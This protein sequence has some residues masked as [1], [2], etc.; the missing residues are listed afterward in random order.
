MKRQCRCLTL[1]SQRCRRSATCGH[2]CQ[3]HVLIGG[4]NPDQLWTEFMQNE[5]FNTRLWIDQSLGDLSPENPADIETIKQGFVKSDPTTKKKYLRW[6]L[7]SYQDGGNHMYQDVVGQMSDALIHFQKIAKLIKEPQLSPRDKDLSTYCGLFG[8]IRKE[9]AMRGLY[10]L[11][12]QY[13]ALSSSVKKS[14]QTSKDEAKK[15]FEDGVATI[16]HPTTK[17][18]AVAYGRGTRWCTS[19]T[20]QNM[21]KEY[22]KQGPLYIIIPKKPHNRAGHPVGSPQWRPD[23]YQ[24]HLPTGSL[25]NEL[26]EPMSLTDYHV[27]HNTL[28]EFLKQ[29]KF[30]PNSKDL[31]GRRPLQVTNNEVMVMLL[32]ELGAEPNVPNGP[33]RWVRAPETIEFLLQHHAD[34][35]V[36]DKLGQTLLFSV[37]DVQTAQLLLKYGADPFIKDNK[38]RTLLHAI[39]ESAVIELLLR[40]GLDPN[41]EDSDGQTPLYMAKT[42]EKMDLLLKSGAKANMHN[43]RGET[44]LHIS[45]NAEIVALLLA[46]NADPNGVNEFGQTPLHIQRDPIVIELLLA[47][48]ANPDAKNQYGSTPLHINCGLLE[49][50]TILLRHKANPNI[51]NMYGE[52]PL[53]SLVSAGKEVPNDWKIV[54]LLLQAGANI[55]AKDLKGKTPLDKTFYNPQLKQFL[56]QHGAKSGKFIPPQEQEKDLV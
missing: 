38:G 33:L 51:K 8:C 37:K 50:V 46:H 42:V 45:N 54:L 5:K 1:K 48:G 32:V 16:Y 29:I 9:T 47:H 30:D 23:K 52:T 36:T 11:L 25:M 24:L 34:P 43:K 12:E 35:N 55:N 7:Q 22:S 31:K 13:P 28:I 14:R 49:N 17:E 15:V 56:S 20:K 53:H 40:I 19:G 4:G 18:A 6:I 2:Y 41:A 10:D 26:D 39:K 3:Q 44:P 27:Y 21:F